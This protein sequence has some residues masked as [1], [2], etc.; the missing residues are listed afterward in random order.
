MEKIKGKIK[1]ESL[2]S[3]ITIIAMLVVIFVCSFGYTT[4]NREAVQETVYTLNNG[5]KV[6][7]ENVSL[8]YNI[9]FKDKNESISFTRTCDE[10]LYKN[11]NIFLH[12]HR[13]IVEAFVNGNKVFTINNSRMNEIVH[14]DSMILIELN[15]IK[16]G[17]E[18][19]LKF[20]PIDDNEIHVKI[21]E[22]NCGTRNSVE[23][24]ILWNDSITL[25]SCISLIILGFAFL[26]FLFV[27]KKKSVMQKRF[28][29]FILFLIDGTIWLLT[30]SAL[31]C[32]LSI[33]YEVV[34]I[35]NYFAFMSL[36]LG[37]LFFIKRSFKEDAKMK[38]IDI[39]IILVIL[40][41]LIKTILCLFRLYPIS[42]LTVSDQVLILVSLL[43]SMLYTYK[44]HREYKGVPSLILL[45]GLSTVLFC[46]VCGLICYYLYDS[47]VYH[48][49]ICLSIVIFLLVLI[50]IILY[51]H[52]SFVSQREKIIKEGEL[53]KELSYKDEL[54][55][56]GNHRKFNEDLAQIEF[57]GQPLYLLIID[58]NNIK[59]V[60]DTYGHG[61]G[62]VL[63]LQC[64]ECMD[65]AFGPF[66]AK[67]YR[68]GGDEFACIINKD[69]INIEEIISNFNDLIKITNGDRMYKLSVAVGYAKYGDEVKTVEQLKFLAD[70]SMYR[71]KTNKKAR[72]DDAE[73]ETWR[74]M[75]DTIISIFEVK[76]AYT[77]QH[78]D[79][80][81]QVAKFI[82]EQ[83][84]LTAVVVHDV[85]LAGNL[86]DVGKIGISDSI[87]NKKGK[88]TDEEFAEIKKH[89]VIG[90]RI[91]L[92]SGGMKKIA[93]IVR[94]HHE[95][96]DGTG[97][98][99][100]LKGDDIPL[101][102]RIL[103]VA[104]CIDAMT[105]DRCY[106]KAM[107]YEECRQEIIRGLGVHF[108]P[109]IGKCAL[110]HWD[111]LVTIHK[112]LKEQ[113]D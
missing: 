58:V 42:Y 14:V 62:D 61:A 100:G 32:L 70:L 109:V 2:I 9:D 92:S 19:T 102:A 112:N 111:E 76:D 52:V 39:N 88:L 41:V 89:P 97:Y 98:P 107:S 73:N 25:I 28:I 87:L 29:S 90:E 95:R 68:T 45:I 75:I 82:A 91:I 105:S 55:G 47:F 1:F 106:R 74:K 54:T 50:I 65:R 27:A 30:D 113:L 36:P 33:N 31:P 84:E 40:N 44:F 86:H 57:L 59:R 56:I 43:S 85:Y 94:A 46:G 4:T 96:F 34:C 6:N 11:D 66:N 10:L 63:I 35:I 38:I 71:D 78:S 3:Y 8:P 60:N 99:D 67:N 18:V 83:M 81:S 21:D 110:D 64:A 15:D 108:D 77:A 51:S 20:A 93:K 101:E 49:I 80:V 16:I 104:D 26:S 5:W 79:R 13:L 17:D 48:T 24:L 72:E 22:I 69:N 37:I 103:T 53:F 12:N 7:D 23:G